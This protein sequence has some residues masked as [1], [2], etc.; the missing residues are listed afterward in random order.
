MSCFLHCYSLLLFTFIAFAIYYYYLTV[1]IY[2]LTG[3]C[4][5]TPTIMGALLFSCGLV[6]I[7][8]MGFDE[9]QT[10]TVILTE[11]GLPIGGRT[12]VYVHVCLQIHSSYSFL[13]EQLKPV[14]APRAVHDMPGDCGIEHSV[15]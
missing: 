7:T 12:V 4:N 14:A 11:D 9:P 5:I 6:E 8:F 10:I 1:I 2:L 15:Q 13:L 3:I